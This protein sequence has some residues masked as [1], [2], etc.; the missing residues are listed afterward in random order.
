MLHIVAVATK[1]LQGF[2]GRWVFLMAHA[3]AIWQPS[4]SDCGLYNQ[5]IMQQTYKKLYTFF[6][7]NKFTMRFTEEKLTNKMIPY[8]QRG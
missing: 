6:K 1:Q 2:G 5:Q 8:P 3:L 4:Q 7:Q